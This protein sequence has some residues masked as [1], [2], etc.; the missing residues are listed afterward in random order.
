[1]IKEPIVLEKK[2]FEL[3]LQILQAI[4]TKKQFDMPKLVIG[5]CGESG[6][7]KTVTAQCLQQTL[8]N[9]G[10]NTVI[11]HMDSYFKI[12]PKDNHLK[13]KENIN[14]VGTQEVDF[15]LLNEHV[16]DFKNLKSNIVIPVVDYLNN[17]FF[18]E[19]INLN[20][21]DVLIIEGVYAFHTAH[22]DIKLFL[23]RTY[24]DTLSVRKERSREVYDHFVEQ[25]LEIEHRLALEQ[26][27]QA[28]LLI[29]KNYNLHYPN[30]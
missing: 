9:K 25:V 21:I 10:K 6:C 22:L 3:S 16:T 19:N 20:P 11:L 15:Q 1:M 23:E 17:L 2:Y 29:D 18:K 26:K 28:D 14:W 12:P 7:G 24:I 4:Q 5:I 8:N 13:R 30:N 27:M